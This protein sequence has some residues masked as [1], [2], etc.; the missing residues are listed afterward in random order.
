[1]IYSDEN[2]DLATLRP[3]LIDVLFLWSFPD[4]FQRVERNTNKLK[5]KQAKYCMNM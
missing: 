2:P 4:A 3:D 1:M 5:G